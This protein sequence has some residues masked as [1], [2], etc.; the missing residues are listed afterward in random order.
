M[1]VYVCVHECLCVCTRARLP[2]LLDIMGKL[3]PGKI[4]QRRLQELAEELLSDSQCDFCIFSARQLLEKTIKHWSKLF[5][6]FVDL[7]KAYDLVPRC[8]LW[9]VLGQYGI[10]EVMIN[11]LRS[12]HN[13]MEAE[14]TISSLTSPS[15]RVTN[16]LHQGCTI[17]P[18]LFALCLN[19]VIECWWDRCKVQG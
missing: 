15:F 13:G 16:G 8:A 18:I 6:L 10:P 11:L 5:M 7:R 3:L 2:S 14:V 1:C 9:K 12:L 17:A 19:C 4:L